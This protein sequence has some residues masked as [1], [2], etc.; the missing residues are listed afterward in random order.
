MVNKNDLLKKVEEN[1]RGTEYELQFQKFRENEERYRTLF[2]TIELG[3]VYHDNNGKIN[4]ANHAAEEIL[5]LSFDQM[6]GRTSTEDMWKS[7]SEDGSD[8]PGEKH[9]AMV[10]LKTGKIVK[11]VIM[12]IFDPK[13]GQ[14]RWINVNATP[15][16]KKDDNK[17]FQVYT[18]FEDITKRKKAEEALNESEEKFSKAFH[19]NSAAMTVTHMGDGLIIDANESFE[20]LFGYTHEETI[21]HSTNELGIW[22]TPQERD[23][24]VEQLVKMG[25]LPLHEVTFGT[26][27][28][29][30]IHVLFSVELI[31]IKGQTYILTTSMDITESK[32]TEKHNQKLLESE[33]QLTEELTTSN[34]ELQSTTEEL[35]VTNEELRQQE[36]KQ[37]N[38]Y[39]ELQES[40]KRLNK[41]LEDL[42]RSE[43]LLSSI[44]NLSSDIIYVKDRQSRLI[45][46]NPAFER[47]EGKGSNELLGKTDLELYSDPEMG[48]KILENDREVMDS[49]EEKIMEEVVQTIDGIRSFISVKTPRFNEKGQVI[50]IVGISHDIT[51]RKQAEYVLQESE[52][53]YRNIIE[54]ANE[55]IMITDPSAVVT[56]ANAKMAEMLGYSIEELLGLNSINLIDKTE[57]EKA[58]Q[59]I[60]DR[61]KGIRGEYELKFLTKNGDVLWTHG[62]VSPMYD[63]EGFHTGNLT[64][65]IDITVRKKAE[66]LNKKLLE[67]EQQLT[68]ELQTSNEELQSISEELQTSNE[69][70]QS[71]SEELQTSN[72]ELKCTSEDLQISNQN[73]RKVLKDHDQ[74]NRTLMALRHSSF[75]MMHATDENLYLNEVCRIIIEDC[76][77]SMV[78]VGF[79]E[80]ETKKVVPVTYFGFEEDYLKTLNITF[81]DTERGRGPTGTAIRT[82]KP[83][84]CENMLVDPKFKPWR[85]EAT[86]RGYASSIVLPITLNNQVI[87]ALTIYSKETNPFS[88]EAT[89]LLQELADDISFGLTALRLRIANTEAEKALQESFLE[90]KRSNAD[91]EQFAYI[92][93]HDLREPLRMITSFLQLLERRYQDRLDSD[94]NEFIGYAVNGAKRLDKMIQDILVYS[95]ITNKERNFVSVNLNNVLEQTYLNLK[96]SINENDAEITN[97]HLPTL[98]VDEQLMV[99]LFQNLI[100]NAIKYRGEKSPKIYISAKRE[101]KQWLFCVKDNGIGISEKHLD[102]IFIIFQRLHTHQE[103]EG[104]GIGLSIAQK[105]VHQHNGNIWVESEIGTGT[106][107]YFTI[108]I[109]Y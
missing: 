79:A 95:K 108:P 61:K 89:K 10:A 106:T 4:F 51:D 72:E 91:L 25:K 99:Q 13:T 22:L 15:Q 3:I 97:D 44:T 45:F 90:V 67:S 9:P 87:G 84:I 65:Y 55:G 60:R 36:E 85:E 105:I 58:K 41:T 57:I 32:K 6:Q 68:E 14:T 43:A 8:F 62:S 81:N 76:G 80:E 107:F 53:K 101:D 2:E 52:Q 7:I 20:T 1:L 24:E 102:K 93:S 46:I 78:W 47:I 37:L 73:L 34:E 38:L 35:Q 17:P 69:E 96:A 56:F 92:T 104:T 12:G 23:A 31:H 26:K 50:G 27:S 70:L 88:E 103:Y 64:M 29:K 82:G 48:K 98:M 75:A 21:G 5:G 59:R 86:K 74:L 28:G 49:G 54:T 40:H 109:R 30:H 94:A 66:I 77:H 63:H 39:N 100:S 83:C 33:Q 19:S 16:F 71:I 42:S 11:N 18:T